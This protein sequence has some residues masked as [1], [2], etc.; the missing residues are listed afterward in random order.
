MNNSLFSAW[1]RKT[2]DFIFFLVIIGLNSC[3]KEDVNPDTCQDSSKIRQ[4]KTDTMVW[5]E[6]TYTEN[7]LLHEFVQAFSYKKYSYN[8]KGQLTK[9]EQALTL[10]PLSCFMPTGSDGEIITD[11]RKAKITKYSSFEYDNVGKPAKKTDYYLNGKQFE[12]LSYTTYE[13]GD[14]RV[15]ELF[16][17]N[18]EG[19]ISEKNTYTYDEKGNIIRDEYYFSDS[20]A[21][22]ILM[23]TKEY[24]LDDK[25][26]PYLIFENEGIPGIFTNRNNILKSIYTDNY[27]GDGYT[28]TVEYSYEYNA[29]GFPVKMNNFTFIY[30]E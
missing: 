9:I 16:R 15:K 2:E 30:G 20:G 21:G 7:C 23:N 5:E 4:V 10:D 3:E 17:H 11:P 28:Y 29:S 22:Y 25:I 1:V 26:N 6:M 24:V 14:D 27:S 8:E 19:G 12:M 18:R 13:Y